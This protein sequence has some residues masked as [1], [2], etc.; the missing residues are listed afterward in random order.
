MKRSDQ[1]AQRTPPP[2]PLRVQSAGLYGEV[3]ALPV[4]PRIAA[5]LHEPKTFLSN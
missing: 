4:S 2:R 5:P 1:Q 3:T